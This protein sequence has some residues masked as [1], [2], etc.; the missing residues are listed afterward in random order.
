MLWPVI[1]HGASGANSRPVPAHSEYLVDAWETEAGLPQNSVTA[2]AQT[3]D[4]YLWLGTF[5]GLVR[6]DGVR[7]TVFDAANTGALASS[8]IIHLLVDRR[9]QLWILSEFGDVTILREGG[10][11]SFGARQEIRGTI[12]HLNESDDGTVWFGDNE[13]GVYAWRDGKM[14]MVF[15]QK[16]SGRVITICP[17]GN[18]LWVAQRRAFGI[19]REGRYQ[20]LESMDNR[21]DAPVESLQRARSGGVWA[22]GR[23]LGLVRFQNAERKESAPPFPVSSV[24]TRKLHE[25][26]RG[27]IWMAMEGQGLLRFHREHG[28]T[29]FQRA[30]GLSHLVLRTLYEDHEGSIWIGTDGG[31]LNRLRPRVFRVV[32]P[33]GMGDEVLS[34]T[35]ATDGA[36]WLGLNYQG[37]IRKVNGRFEPVTFPPHLGLESSVW[38]VLADGAGGVWT[39]D[40]AGGLLR[41]KEGKFERF[42]NSQVQR[43]VYLRALLMDREGSIWAGEL[44]GLMQFKEG[45]DPLFRY[46]GRAD[47][48]PHEDIRALAEDDRGRLFIA[49]NGGGLVVRENEKFST[50]GKEHGLSDN[51]VWSLAIDSSG[52]GTV[53]V[54]TFG[55]GL[56]RFQAGK[57]THVGGARGLPARVINSLIEDHLG[58]LWVGS[59]QGIFRVKLDD[60][61]AFA[62]GRVSEL[63]YRRFDGSDGMGSMEC[64]GGLQPAAWRTRDNHLW[65]ATIQGVAVVDPANLPLNSKPPP[66]VIEEV[67]VH[68]PQKTGTSTT[69]PRDQN[70]A[71]RDLWS[72][73]KLADSSLKR[74]EQPEILVPPGAGRLEIHYTGLSFAAPQRVRFKYQMEGLDP[75][76]V[77]AETRRVAYYPYLPPGHYRFRVSACNNDGIWNEAGTNLS[78]HVQ[79][80]WWQTIW[81]RAALVVLAGGLVLGL[82]ESRIRRLTR[83]RV[84][85][86]LMSRRLIESQEQER[87]RIAAELHDSLGQN[88]LIIKNRAVIGLS[89]AQETE[90]EAGEQ[91]HEIS[92]MASQALEEV[93]SISHDLR[94]YQLDRLGLTKAIK[95]LVQK[96]SQAANLPMAIDLDPIDRLLSPEFEINLYRVVQESLNNLV[97]HS[98]ARS[99]RVAIRK[100][101]A[102]LWLTIEDD[103]KGFFYAE[104]I[105]ASPQGFGL[106]GIAERVR[107]LGGKLTYDAAPGRGTRVIIEIPI[108]QQHEP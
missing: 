58:Y 57:F 62:E 23:S 15:A 47:G 73:R 103:G 92:R 82:Y 80:H 96:V 14:E 39:S 51:H 101:A 7:F 95:A 78:F 70:H 38:T 49:T 5:N 81:F 65:F 63:N 4:G 88:L 45:S 90:K 9:G 33:H 1:L 108:A 59:M 43:R 50:W 99:A 89:K 29:V 69:G 79:P 35:E 30:E 102:K 104:T 105:G 17:E 56:N 83:A 18:T 91:L 6:F 19:W 72:E 40:N 3:P 75:D 44:G 46:F 13:G 60:L 31:G 94:P 27:Q 41:W 54:G 106:S 8:R 48:L 67:L 24:M 2:I 10:F 93:R 97:K 84:A 85:Q 25:D 86:E 87:K 74:P 12:Q 71:S 53:W 52:N 42:M 98:G 107:I 61:N 28:W 34:V 32:S 26:A 21:G 77:D 76:W 68:V 22:A 55:G 100:G 11:H 37:L 16:E 36:V 66:V 20:W 64:S